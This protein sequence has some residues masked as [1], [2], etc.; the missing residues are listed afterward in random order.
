[1]GKLSVQQTIGLGCAIGELDA[2]NDCGH[3]RLRIA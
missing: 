1:M 2:V 3:P